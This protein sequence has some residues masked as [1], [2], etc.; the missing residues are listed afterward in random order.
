MS[1]KKSEFIFSFGV[2]I[3]LVC[4][5]NDFS[6]PSLDGENQVYMNG[7]GFSIV[8]FRDLIHLN[9]SLIYSLV[10]P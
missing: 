5:K 7:I 4:S 3:W 9:F 8:F 2:A 6:E 10:V 1:L